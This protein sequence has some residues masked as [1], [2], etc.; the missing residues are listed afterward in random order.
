VR[1]PPFELERYFAAYEFATELLL[2]ASDIEG[3]RMSELLAMADDEA[4]GLWA[5][6]SL[7]YTESAGHPLLRAEIASLYDGVEPDDVLVFAG[8]EEAI[9]VFATV[10]A[11][12]GNRVVCTWPAYQSLYEVGQAAGAHIGLVRL[13][14]DRSWT[15]DVDEVLNKIDSTTAAV[16]VNFPH[17]PTGAI[18]DREPFERLLGELHERAI[19]LLSDEVYRYMEHDPL[20]RLPAAVELS[21]SA[22]SLGVMSKAFALA[23]LRIG[24]IA[25]KNRRQLQ[26]LAELKDYT[27]ICN[28]A[29]SEILAIIALRARDQ[30]LARNQKILMDNLAVLDEFFARR[31][32][33][34]Q[35]VRPRGGATGFPELTDRFD[36]SEFVAGLARERG[37][38]LLPGGIYGFPG[39]HFRLGFGRT[40]MPEALR[41]FEE[42]A[43]SA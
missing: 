36:I 31:G 43:D 30:L 33:L 21:G 42:Y 40:N 5:D 24:W 37:V 41:R 4:G 39:N 38:L 17:N 8:A 27:S 25:T 26:R 18:C 20:H 23:G 14:Y 12:K 34:V 22:L 13:E 15:F 11:S 6:L 16:I 32:D 7:G 2:C 3:L 28:S 29:P 9:F 35:W 1:I 10:V 19:P